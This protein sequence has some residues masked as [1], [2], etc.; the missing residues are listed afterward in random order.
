M[1]DSPEERMELIPESCS[2][3]NACPPVI[4]REQ[5]RIKV[6]DSPVPIDLP[7]TLY[8]VQPRGIA[9]VAVLC[10]NRSSGSAIFINGDYSS[11]ES[12]QNFFFTRDAALANFRAKILKEAQ[13]LLALASKQE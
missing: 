8:V 1:S 11:T 10:L 13:D 9:E 2:T 4:R 7:A 6:I 5:Q 3:H 12:V